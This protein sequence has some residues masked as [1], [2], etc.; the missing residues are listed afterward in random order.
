MKV[1]TVV[2][3]FNS[4]SSRPPLVGAY[5]PYLPSFVQEPPHLGTSLTTLLFL[6]STMVA[7]STSMRATWFGFI[8]MG[9]I[10]IR[11]FTP[12]CFSG[13]LQIVAPVFALNMCRASL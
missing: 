5:R 3:F 2:P 13:S 10:L 12:A 9:T 11:S 7:L 1:R 6:M 4:S 8:G